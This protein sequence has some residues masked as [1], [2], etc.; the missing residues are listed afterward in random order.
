MD[1]GCRRVCTA[2][3]PSQLGLSSGGGSERAGEGERETEKG[4][5][6]GDERRKTEQREVVKEEERRIGNHAVPFQT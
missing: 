3:T 5:D 6:I 4:N 2:E 1:W